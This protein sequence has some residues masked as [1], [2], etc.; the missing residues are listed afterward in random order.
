[1][2]HVSDYDLKLS[3]YSPQR[4]Q[5]QRFVV[6]VAKKPK[7]VTVR[8]D[9]KRVEAAT[10]FVESPELNRF[11]TPAVHHRGSCRR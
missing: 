11:S 2:Q 1:M 7:K 10:E 3:V 6:N 8:V 9:G 5:R 4:G